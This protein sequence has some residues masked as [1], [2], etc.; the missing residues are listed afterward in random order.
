VLSVVP[1][2]LD[3]YEVLHQVVVLPVLRMEAGTVFCHQLFAGTI[4]LIAGR[5]YL[6]FFTSRHVFFASLPSRVSPGDYVGQRDISGAH[7]VKGMYPDMYGFQV[8]WCC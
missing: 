6:P 4:H 3:M 8:S 7:S 2:T 1:K 5:R